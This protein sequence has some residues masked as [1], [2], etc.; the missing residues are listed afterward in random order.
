MAVSNIRDSASS[1]GNGQP[2]SSQSMATAAYAAV[3]FGQGF[4]DLYVGFAD[5]RYGL[6]R[7]AQGL[8]EDEF[9]SA[10]GLADGQQTM[11]GARVGYAF[12]PAKGVTIGPVASLDYVRSEL[13]GYRE[14][15]AGDFSLAIHDR[16]YTSIGAKL[17]LMGALDVKLG[18]TSKLS[19]FG[20]VA[21]ARELGDRVDTVT[22]NFL[23]AEDLPFAISR[24]LAEDWV[25][26]NA[27]AQLQ[28][29][30]N[31]TTQFSLSSDLGRDELSNH[32]GRAT[33]NWKF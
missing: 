30:D 32:Q 23:G 21:Y 12:A 33:L 17:G 5:Q 18:Q 8:L 2:S 22:A 1:L 14:T 31:V 13:E 3:G 7:G 24:Q 4:A 20:S 19:L 28:L 9:R 15:E 11:A 16:T 25:A 26:V 6:E 10:A 29:S 27:G